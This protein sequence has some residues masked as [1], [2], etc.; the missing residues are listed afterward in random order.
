MSETKPG[1]SSWTEEEIRRFAREEA[2][3]VYFEVHFDRVDDVNR[4][5]REKYG[6]KEPKQ[7]PPENA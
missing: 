2:I 1:M 5:I 3:Q 4:R 6:L 7:S